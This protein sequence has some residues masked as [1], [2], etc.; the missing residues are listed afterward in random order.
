MSGISLNESEC[1]SV[2]FQRG[3]GDTI[4]V[5]K[6]RKID[7]KDELDGTGTT[8]KDTDNQTTESNTILDIPYSG[9]ERQ[10]YN[11]TEKGDEK[12]EIGSDNVTN[13]SPKKSIRQKA[14][15][16]LKKT[17]L[18]VFGIIL[19]SYDIVTDIQIALSYKERNDENLFRYTVLT[20][21]VSACFIMVIDVV[22]LL[23]DYK[24]ARESR[25][26]SAEI[27]LKTTKGSTVRSTE[28]QKSD[29]LESG[30]HLMNTADV[31]TSLLRQES[32]Q[33]TE[34]GDAIRNDHRNQNQT[35]KGTKMV[36]HVRRQGNPDVFKL[37]LRIVLT[38]MTVG[39]GGMICRTIQ[40]MY[41]FFKSV[42]T[43]TPARHEFYKKK[44]RHMQRDCL[45]MSFIEAFLESAPQFALQLYITYK[46]DRTFTTLRVCTLVTSALS[47]SWS[48]SAYYRCNRANIN[49]TE[50]VKLIPLLIYF[51]SVASCIVPRFIS[52]VFFAVYFELVGLIT[53]FGLIG[54]HLAVG[55]VV[56][57]LKVKPEL[58]GTAEHLIVRWL[59][60]A[61]FAYVKFF[62]FL[63]LEHHQ[64]SQ[65]DRKKE[66]SIRRNWFEKKNSKK[67][68][69]LLY[70]LIHLENWI[71][72]TILV[73]CRRELMADG[74]FVLILVPIGTLVQL[75]C[76]SSYYYCFHTTTG[77]DLGRFI[78]QDTSLI[79]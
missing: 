30:D 36:W 45:M 14:Y 50:D 60:Y 33:T 64:L 31:D 29:Q 9:M 70:A 1:D 17:L 68:M 77:V 16:C 43:S 22:W 25:Y 58:K 63:N 35:S 6:N 19:Y 23:I 37:V 28:F 73:F 62:L 24:K 72:A 51:L 27:E 2:P 4:P 46:L 78:F 13:V 71:L 56:I 53:V 8:A 65:T 26:P 74:S 38:V 21:V 54:I 34:Q 67:R 69:I 11:N 42:L 55:L 39:T 52:F 44:A 48:Y 32:N 76:L 40:Y 41:Y 5:K 47:I 75:I 59:C 15:G 7:V 79:L 20:L 10:T 18:P 12:S 49:N 61:F 57:S 66:T 3:N